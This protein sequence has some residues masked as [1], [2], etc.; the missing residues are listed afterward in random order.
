MK[1]YVHMGT[2][3]DLYSKLLRHVSVSVVGRGGEYGGFYSILASGLQCLE[4]IGL[5]RSVKYVI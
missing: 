4:M 2:M 5:Y 1:P 3:T